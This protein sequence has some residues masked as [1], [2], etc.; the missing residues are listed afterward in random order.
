[1]CSIGTL[2]AYEKSKFPRSGLEEGSRSHNIAIVSKP[3]CN[4]YY[5][6]KPLNVLLK[7]EKPQS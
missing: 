1:M 6:I 7:E 2:R 3:R 5:N 4:V